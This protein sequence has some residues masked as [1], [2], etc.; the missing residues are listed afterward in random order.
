[1]VA[2]AGDDRQQQI[3]FLA[4]RHVERV[5]AHWHDPFGLMHGKPL[6]FDR[7]EL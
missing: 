5:H 6:E 3:R 4:G 2:R 1:M 7:P